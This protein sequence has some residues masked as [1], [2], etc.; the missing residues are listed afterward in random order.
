MLKVTNYVAMFFQWNY[1]SGLSVNAP[2]TPPRLPR[3]DKSPPFASSVCVTS[4]KTCAFAHGSRNI[5]DAAFIPL[6]LGTSGSS[7]PRLEL[8]QTMMW[9]VTRGRGWGCGWLQYGTLNVL[10]WVRSVCIC[11]VNWRA[12]ASVLICALGC[13]MFLFLFFCVF[14]FFLRLSLCI[15][16]N[17]H[18]FYAHLSARQYQNYTD[19]PCSLSIG[20]NEYLVVSRTCS[21]SDKLAPGKLTATLSSVDLGA[22][23]NTWL[24]QGCQ[25][26]STRLNSSV[27]SS[28][29]KAVFKASEFVPGSMTPSRFRG[30]WW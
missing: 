8:K 26:P 9:F 18:C 19:Q 29:E 7:A 1:V 6:A 3:D 2:P 16:K 25:Y 4:H 5:C 23:Y 11:C 28:R 24:G 22:N 27:F 13:F 12:C 17:C 15:C 21:V 14:F 30:S 10:N 20:L